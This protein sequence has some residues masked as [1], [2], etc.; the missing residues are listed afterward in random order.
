MS[1]VS[2]NRTELR[3]HALG[4]GLLEDLTLDLRFALSGLRRNPT[5]TVVAALTIAVGMGA[6]TAMLSIANALLFRPPPITEPDD[7]V[8]IWEFRSGSVRESMEGRLLPYARYEAY[9]EATTDVFDDL[10]GH[11]YATLSIVTD[12]GAVALDGF[13]T[14]GNYFQVL[15]VNPQ[16]GRLSDD[17]DEEAV[18]L[19][20]RLWRGRYGADPDVVGR[21]VAIDSRSFTIVG[22]AAP[23]FVGTMAG[24]TGDVWLP[25]PAYRRLTGLSEN[26]DYVV[27]LGRLRDGVDRS[28]AEARIDDVA[29]NIPPRS[30]TTVQGARLEGLLWR[31]DLA[32]VLN[33]AVAM[34][35]SAAALVLLIAVANIAAMMQA[36]SYERRREIAVRRAIGAGGGRLVRQMIAESV[37][38][39]L[40]GGTGGVA[41][42]AA[43]TAAL[44]SIDL[45]V[46]AT[47]TFDA[48]PDARVLV[49]SFAIAA[50]T[51]ILFGLGPALRSA[52]T[53]LTTS[54][55]EGAQ[56]ARMSRRKNVFVVGQLA[57]ST[58]L[59]VTAGLF[60]RSMVAV[61]N[62]P[63]GFDP[64]GVMV[65]TFSLASHGYGE[66]R[67]RAFF[68]QLL[69]RVRSTPGVEAAGL[70]SFVPLGGA[71]AS[72]DGRPADRGEDPPRFDVGYNI[73]DPGFF[74]A[75]R[76]E[77]VEGR[78]IDD[79]DVPGPRRSAVVN[80]ALA[81]RMWP[82]RSAVGR[83]YRVGFTEYEVVGV[84]R[85]GVYVFVFESKPAFAFYSFQQRYSSSMS[86]H[87]R[88]Q[89]PLPP[90]GAAIRDIVRDL[91]PNVAV[92]GLRT[93]EEIVTSSRFMVGF[94]AQLTTLFAVVGLLLAA[95]GV[96]G[97]LA[98]QVA[99]RG[100][101]FGVRMA[102]GARARDVLL[103]VI[104]RGAGAAA[105]GW[106]VGLGLSAGGGG[107]VG[108]LLYGVAPF[109]AVTFTIVPVVLLATAMIA[110]FVP[111][112]RATRV[113]PTVMLRAE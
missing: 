65:G 34:M 31:T 22:V 101:E 47:L 41:I 2:T 68:G 4:G 58:L 25:W 15:G 112:R 17:G 11:S 92:E 19:S 27:P 62:V 50:L 45:P 33:V 14:T 89:G 84:A 1:T 53:D 109:D 40:I 51:G 35:L 48:T 43:G 9:R 73:V 61:R 57:L 76:V 66:E 110:S 46:N 91:D 56:G 36:R 72:H 103:L 8:A 26:A 70:G 3:E 87:V 29:R 49:A 38:L 67:G 88:A 107:A 78:F 10:A 39:A 21:G 111:A 5:F 98:V 6:T 52:R 13:R 104:G 37:L 85:D 63:L 82:G 24:F 71:N 99:Q 32:E 75:N 59:L 64:G 96:Y 69:E 20:D 54:L 18:V 100:R 90:I 95:V 16:I 94:V 60:A 83:V 93:M 108:S 102:P 80:E 28:A 74:E 23:G 12:A 7:V 86:L 42:A 81:E 97:L 105:I 44:S 55:K 77:L 113:S 79:S 106:V 30:G